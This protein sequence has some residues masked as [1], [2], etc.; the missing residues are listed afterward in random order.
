[1]LKCWIK[2]ADQRPTF[3]YCLETLKSIEAKTSPFTVITMT[4]SDT[5]KYWSSTSTGSSGLH[6]GMNL[7]TATGSGI[8]I[9]T[10]QVF[11]PIEPVTNTNCSDVTKPTAG[12]PKYLELMYDDSQDSNSEQSLQIPVQH[13]VVPQIPQGMI[14]PNSREIQS[15]SQRNSLAIRPNNMI[16]DDGYEIPISDFPNDRNNNKNTVT[17]SLS[18]SSTMPS[19]DPEEIR[20]SL[21]QALQLLPNRNS[22][23]LSLG[24]Q[25]TNKL[26]NDSHSNESLM[27]RNVA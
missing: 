8:P 24:K 22:H 3:R 7:T 17:R 2:S 27:Q 15:V 21:E 18:N 13:S 5:F 25:T 9:R 23:P 1:M 11:R 26:I 6:S 4:T 10:E 20:R 16:T 19:V 12:V 14:R